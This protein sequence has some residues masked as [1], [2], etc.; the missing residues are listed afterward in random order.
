LKLCR[1]L[2]CY[3]PR[4]V[5]FDSY[6]SFFDSVEAMKCQIKDINNFIKTETQSVSE[7]EEKIEEKK[8]ISNG[9]I[10]NNNN[11]NNDRNMTQDMTISNAEYLQL[12]NNRMEN[13]NN[14]NNNHNNETIDF[15]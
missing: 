10:N 6:N 9:N 12:N 4:N 11:K 7:Y 1:I 3:K 8:N 14:N 13:I 2:T 5:E 15:T